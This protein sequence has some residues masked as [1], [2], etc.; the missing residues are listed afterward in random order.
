MV[1]MQMAN[2]VL[3][4]E[5]ILTTFSIAKKVTAKDVKKLRNRMKSAKIDAD[6]L[7]ELLKKAIVKE[8]QSTIDT[9]HIPGLIVAGVE[10]TEEK[11]KI[12]ELTYFAS[13][14][15]K[16]LSDKKI[17]KYHSCY[18]INAIVNMLGLTEEDFDEFHK[19]FSKFRDDT[20]TND[21]EEYE[22]N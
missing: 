3:A 21:G 17:G 1:R 8:V 18:I 7:N 20:N 5:G 9:Q 15:A 19:K 16:K 6:K 2:H 14:V 13:I 12:M 22:Q 11:K 4:K 10:E